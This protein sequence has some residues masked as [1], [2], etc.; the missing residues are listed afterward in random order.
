MNIKEIAEKAGVSVA[1]ISRVLNHPE[2]VQIETRQH[3]LDIMEKYNYTPSWFARGLNLRRTQTI[4]AVVPDIENSMYQ[5]LIAGIESVAHSKDYIIFLCLTHND[6]KNE[7]NYLNIIVNRKV[8]GVVF[9][10]SSLKEKHFKVLDKN[11]IPY[12]L[13][14]QDN[15]NVG[16]NSCYINFEESAFKMTRHLVELGHN[17]IDLIVD[18]SSDFKSKSMIQGYRDGMKSMNKK[19]GDVHYCSNNIDEG[20]LTS[21]RLISQ[22]NMA[23][24][25]F[26]SDDE[27]AFGVMKAAWEEGLQVPDDVAI[28]G[29][30]NSPMASLIKPE[31]T[32]VEQPSKKLGMVAA[33]MLFDF[34]EDEEFT[35]QMSQEII[36]QPTIKIRRSCGNKKYIYELFK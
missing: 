14:G 4:A 3:V 18:K 12:V 27:I 24:A 16:Q 33:R 25:L 1:T 19:A 6:I 2:L 15:E 31:L 11:N 5:R 30:S 17:D 8:D 36:L 10:A 35:S 9:A 28:A 23:R 34:L 7:L 21:K 29:F 32:S 22:G 20:Y 13:V 26:T